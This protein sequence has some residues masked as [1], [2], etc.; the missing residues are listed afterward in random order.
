VI[1]I[2]G[3]EFRK[4]YLLFLLYIYYFYIISFFCYNYFCYKTKIKNDKIKNDK[5]KNDKKIKV[6]IKI[7]LIY[8]KQF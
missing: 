5:I 1:G 4:Y 7:T 6:K 2:L 3:L 8:K